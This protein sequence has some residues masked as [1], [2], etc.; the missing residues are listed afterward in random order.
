SATIAVAMV[1][2]DGGNVHGTLEEVVRW[3]ERTQ[4]HITVTNWDI[5]VL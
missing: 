5:E 1:S 2:S 4:P 3:I